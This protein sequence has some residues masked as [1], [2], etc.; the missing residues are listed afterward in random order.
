MEQTTPSKTDSSI[1]WHHN[2]GIGNFK[3]ICSGKATLPHS[4][5]GSICTWVLILV[6][7]ALQIAFVNPAYG[8]DRLWVGVIVQVTYIAT[9]VSAL[10]ALVVTTCS[11]PGI[12]PR[13]R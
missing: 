11:D 5:Y 2:K 13:E 10:I 4:W 8:N 7:S 1:N 6:P 3:V 9:M 12:V